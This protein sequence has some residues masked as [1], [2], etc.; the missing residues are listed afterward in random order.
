MSNSS[1]DSEPEDEGDEEVIGGGV[2]DDV[3]EILGQLEEGLVVGYAHQPVS[4]TAE[5][6]T[7]TSAPTLLTATRKTEKYS[8]RVG[9]TTDKW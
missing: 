1:L 6:T 2:D 8:E 4:V 3:V 7:S 5:S 9:G